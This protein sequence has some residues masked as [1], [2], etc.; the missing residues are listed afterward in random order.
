[1]A[2]RLTELCV[3]PGLS[4][5]SAHSGSVFVSDSPVSA[6]R[7]NAHDRSPSMIHRSYSVVQKIIQP[8]RTPVKA[9]LS[10]YRGFPVRLCFQCARQGMRARSVP[11]R[12]YFGF[13]TYRRIPSAKEHSE[14]TERLQRPMNADERRFPTRSASGWPRAGDRMAPR[15]RRDRCV[16]GVGG[17]R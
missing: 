8:P 15:T 9:K 13:R 12:A 11:V 10:P 14:H 3:V 6:C 17:S 1:M 5:R 4:S 2:C 7:P 16:G